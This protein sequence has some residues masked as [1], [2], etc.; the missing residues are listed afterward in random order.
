MATIG[1]AVDARNDQSVASM[2][3]GS[4]LDIIGLQCRQKTYQLAVDS[5]LHHAVSDLIKA[6]EGLGEMRQAAF[7]RFGRLGRKLKDNVA[8][9]AND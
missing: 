4:G 6:A 2:N 3:L 9:W 8:N 1:F 5:K 7:E